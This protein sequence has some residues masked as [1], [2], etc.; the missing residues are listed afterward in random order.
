M[1]KGQLEAAA[2]IGFKKFDVFKKV[3]LTQAANNVFLL[4][5]GAFVS[6]VKSTSIVGYK[7]VRKGILYGRKRNLRGRNARTDF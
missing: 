2:A 1:D 5:K 7:H 4:Y 6:L 3:I